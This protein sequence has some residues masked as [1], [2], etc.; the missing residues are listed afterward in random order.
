M[1]VGHFLNDGH[2]HVYIWVVFLINSLKSYRIA[3]CFRTIRVSYREVSS[4][5]ANDTAHSLYIR[6]EFLK[7]YVFVQK[8]CYHFPI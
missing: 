2:K 7:K 6:N 1:G 3:I 8:E 5:Y 4:R